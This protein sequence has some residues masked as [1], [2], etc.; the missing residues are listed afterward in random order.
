MTH[1]SSP[2]LR[3]GTGSDGLGVEITPLCQA[4]PN[5][6]KSSGSV[7]PHGFLKRLPNR[8]SQS[9][10]RKG[11]CLPWEEVHPLFPRFT[12]LHSEGTAGGRP[13]CRLG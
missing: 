2:V 8:G 9:V 3:I 13:D 1:A 4:K 7:L 10:R 12:G 6:V 5:S 11:N